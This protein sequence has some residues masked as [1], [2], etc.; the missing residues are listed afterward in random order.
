MVELI[1][2]NTSPIFK[3][4]SKHHPQVLVS[5]P[6]PSNV[7]PSKCKWPAFNVE[8]VLTHQTIWGLM[9]SWLTQHLG[10]DSLNIDS[11]Y[12]SESYSYI[13]WKIATLFVR[14]LCDSCP[15]VL[16][17]DFFWPM[18][19]WICSNTARFANLLQTII[20]KS[21]C[22]CQTLL[23]IGL[24]NEF[25]HGFMALCFVIKLC[26][27]PMMNWIR[28]NIS[29]FINHFSKHH[30]QALLPMPNPSLYRNSDWVL[31]RIHGHVSCAY[32]LFTNGWL[33]FEGTYPD[34]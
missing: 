33:E 12:R 29:R 25:C 16:C 14:A 3:Q 19:N 4:F 10:D 22:Q 26:F 30:Q 27:W 7:V 6:N 11:T 13:I 24:L 9:Y 18:V 34:F 2:S 15:C 21:L 23:C 1:V 17:S 5:M 31:S 8:S 32:I 20:S 28:S